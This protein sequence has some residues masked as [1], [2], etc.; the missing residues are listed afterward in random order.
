ML[1]TV[2]K[3]AINYA[4]LEIVR[5]NSADFRWSHTVEDYNPI[6]PKPRWRKGHVPHANL[7][8]ILDR[9]RVEY[10]VFLDVMLKNANLLQD[11]AYDPEN[12]HSDLPFWNNQLFSALD[13]GAL[14]TVIAW[15]RPAHYIEIGS[16]QS[17]RFARYAIN[18]L[19]LGTKITSI[20][21]VPRHNI[22][23][24]CDRI[25]RSPLETCDLAIF[26][27]LKAGDIL[28]VDGSHRA[29]SNSDVT[30]CFF[31]IMPRLKSGVI[32]HF[33]DIFIPD[34]Y[35]AVWNHRLYNEQYI[36]AA[37]LMCEKPPFRVIAPIALIGQDEALSALA[38]RAFISQIGGRDIPFIYPNESN[39]PGVSF[40]LEME[41]LGRHE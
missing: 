32:V 1:K 18:T 6:T 2:V 10:E 7:C 33:H 40:W 16:G 11:I 17:T 4:G 35:P 30:V 29:F 38:K 9:N 20:D 27:D 24:I 23:Q 36:L 8:E 34:D 41:A 22:D 15:K 12:E 25:I 37:M 13:A 26:G 31:E 3:K 21:P 28:F 14:V 5:S 19:K 39:T